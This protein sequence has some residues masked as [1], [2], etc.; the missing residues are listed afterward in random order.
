M[1]EKMKALFKKDEVIFAVL[2]ILIY[3]FSF[4]NA[5]MISESIGAPKSITVCAGLILSLLLIH[6]VRQNKLSEYFGLCRIKCDWKSL[7]CLLPLIP[8][9]SINVLFGFHAPEYLLTALRSV[10]CM[11]FVGF[12]EELIF[13]GFLFKAMC[14]SNVRT[15]IIVSSFTFGVGHIINLLLG[16][17]L[18][19]TLLQLAYASSVGF[20]YTALFYVSGSIIPCIVSHAL[21]NSLSVFINDATPTMLVITS[22]LQI[23]LSTGYGIWLLRHNPSGKRCSK[24]N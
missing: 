16:E 22:V 14:K 18:L 5:D 11:C 21:V 12:L 1:E 20:C 8:I 4:S 6:F 3:I 10:A 2:W 9:S 17:P 19:E 15:A 13:R 24:V 7:N 23:V